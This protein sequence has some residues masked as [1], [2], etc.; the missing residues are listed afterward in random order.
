MVGKLIKNEL[1]AGLHYVAPI[2]IAT[3]AVA[4]ILAIS[5]LFEIVWLAGIA[6]MAFLI[7]AFGVL[8]VTLISV[9]S[10]FN[11]SMFRDQGYL[12]FTLP[13]TSGQLLFAK[14]LCSFIWILL[15]YIV[16]I[17]MYAG[18]FAYLYDQLDKETLDMLAQILEAFDKLPDVA[19]L[20]ILVSFFLI[21]FFINIVFLVSEIYFSVALANTRIFQKMGLLS[22]IGIF[23]VTFLTT[24][25]ANLLIKNH[26]PLSARFTL[27][28]PYAGLEI[29]FEPMSQSGAFGFADVITM[30][31]G[32]ALFFLATAWFMKHK[33]NL[34]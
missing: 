2:Y 9:I 17:G 19:S 31:I 13:V 27:T 22:T 32:S 7:V 16:F 21:Y 4:A 34:K 33:I 24:T 10:N 26:F 18:M 3:V 25:I 14:A 30:L 20:V 8:A 28:G 23:I 6:L 12:T 5:F 1:K 29:L 15:S 11:K